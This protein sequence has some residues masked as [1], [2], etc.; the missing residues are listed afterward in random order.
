[1]WSPIRHPRPRSRVVIV[2]SLQLSGAPLVADYLAGRS[3]AASFHP[4][5][6]GPDAPSTWEE[7]AEG[8]VGAFEAGARRRLAD[9]LEGGGEDRAAR[10]R[11]FVEEDGLAITTGQQPGLL[12][13]PLYSLYKALTAAALARKV[14]AHLGRPVLPVFWIA[15]EDHDWDEARVTALPNLQN[16]LVE[17]EMDIPPGAAGRPLHRCPIG[18]DIRPVLRALESALPDTDFSPEW[19]DRVRD[20]YSPAHSLPEAFRQLLAPLLDQA[21]IF[22]LLPHRLEAKAATRDL[23]LREAEAAPEREI[24]LRTRAGELEDAGYDLQVPMLDGATNLFLEGPEGRERLFLEEDGGFRL[25]RSG[26]RRSLADL[27]TLTAGDPTLL[28]AG[29]LLRPVVERALVPTLAYVAGPGE[30][31]YLPQTA[32]LFQAHGLSRP[33]TVP[34]ASGVILESKVA[35]VLDRFD[36][37]VEDFDQS[38]HELA[39]QVLRDELPEEVRQ[40]L[41]R[42]RGAVG[43]RTAELNTAVRTVDPTLTGTVGSLRSQVFGL[44]DDLEKKLVQALRRNRGTALAQLEKAAVHLFPGGRPQE[45]VL[46]PLYY[47]VRYGSEAMETWSGLAEEAATALVPTNLPDAPRV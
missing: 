36:L 37:V 16:D 42:F 46:P 24:A 39:G 3:P 25:R 30:L 28:S 23:L 18:E 5:L 40:A 10:L 20:A 15:S 22:T 43:E 12:G 34:R 21:G 6:P 14:E 26:A 7:Q 2:D 8:M 1:M 19:M 33:L 4:P 17:L 11:R 32:P 38:L 13:G 47:L 44:A 35:K 31:A 9:L 41:G 45:R 29:V 27:Q